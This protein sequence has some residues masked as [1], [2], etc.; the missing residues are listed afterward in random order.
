MYIIFCKD[1]YFFKRMSIKMLIFILASYIIIRY[2][3]LYD[4]STFLFLHIQCQILK[5]GPHI[6]FT[7]PFFSPYTE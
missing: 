4:I 2:F 7:T 6:I 1:N 5:A 3:Y